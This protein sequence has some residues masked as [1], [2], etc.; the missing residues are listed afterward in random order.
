MENTIDN[1]ERINNYI[2][3]T[4]TETERL[5]FEKQLQTDDTFNTLYTEHLTLLE[6][7]KRSDLR[8]EILTARKQ[9]VFK[10]WI[11][12]IGL[13]IL[14]IIITII[15][16]N[17][18][19]NLK[20]KEEQ[21]TSLTNDIITITQDST[22]YSIENTKHI[23]TTK[24]YTVIHKKDT[25]VLDKEKTIEHKID[26]FKKETL[27]LSS[28]KLTQEEFKQQFPKSKHLK[29][30]NDS[31][32][33]HT[34]IDYESTLNDHV[35][36]TQSKV[37]T[38]T[39]NSI[40]TFYNTVKK[41]PQ[42]IT[43]N[44]E[45]DSTFVCKEGTLLTIKANSFID[46]KTEKPVG[47]NIN[48]K[49]TEFYKLSDMLLA[50]LSTKSNDD[51][52]ETA[53]MI[54]IEAKKNNTL[55]KL[56]PDSPISIGFPKQ[57]NKKRM[58]LFS[59]TYNNHDINWNVTG[60]E[61]V[62]DII[63]TTTVESTPQVDFRVV[64]VPPLFPSC[65]TGTNKEKKNC[66]KS[67][68]EAFVSKNYNLDVAKGL[69]ITGKQKISVLF[70]IDTKGNITSLKV[71]ASHKKLAEEAIRVMDSL[72]QLEPA[73]QRGKPVIVPFYFPINLTFEGP[74]KK[75]NPVFV[76]GRD[77]AFKNHFE[78]KLTNN[79]IGSI[80]VRE[81]ER[82]MFS[83]SYLGWINCDRF[84]NTINNIKYKV[85]IKNADGA[86]IKMVFKSMSSILPSKLRGENH[87]F[88]YIPKGE[89][90][91]LIG[92]KK[93]GDKI[94][95]GIKETETKQISELDLE[96]KEV[97]I[98]ELKGALIDLNNDFN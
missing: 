23:D 31:I 60:D 70:K 18:F 67:K 83:S 55:L 34:T 46:S 74:T 80:K 14:A 53:G 81:I 10:K 88:G 25:L 57:K 24:H 51:I 11:K 6:G 61:I 7:I 68:I 38:P 79:T 59:G 93:V 20:T 63:T 85:K 37:K 26:Y 73:T 71:G 8:K 32:I 86:N 47:G 22:N 69:N 29:P 40:N 41:S 19:F 35:V 30:V 58:Q 17:S 98:E 4:L 15:C 52:L 84:T 50:N 95:L 5:A 39:N 89:N 13:P 45:K 82:Y 62:E 49:V 90:V 94:Y 66:F 12:L 27:T 1:I 16:Y 75:I 44:T 33:I 87:D 77:V 2:N 92:I 28:N 97:S 65:K 72:P 48:L 3:N 56:K 91:S 54:N 64:E 43:L 36:V 21:N 96:F 78:A 76:N 9:Y 42:I